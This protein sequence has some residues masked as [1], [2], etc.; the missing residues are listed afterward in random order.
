M[1]IL[2]VT[3]NFT[4][5]GVNP[6][7]LD[8]LAAAL[9]DAGHDVDVIVHSP[10]APRPRG[11]SQG[12]SPRIRILSVGATTQPSSAIAKLRFYLATAVRLHTTGARFAAASVYDLAIYPSIAAFS[13]G[14]PS[15]MRRKGIARRLL[16]VMWDFFPIHQMEI[17]R[18]KPAAIAPALKAIERLAIRR[19]DTIAVMSPANERFLAAYHR[20]LAA[21]I[22]H[23]PPWAATSTAGAPP[24]EANPNDGF[25]AVFGGQ[26]VK[27]RGVDTLLDAAHE[28][29]RRGVPAKI[30][31]AGAG[32]DAASLHAKAKELGL[33]SVEFVGSLPRDEY[34]ALLRRSQAGIAVTVAGVTPPSFPSKIIEYCAS[35][36]PV[37]ACVEQSSDAGSYLERHG[38]GVSVS[39]GDHMALADAI[40]GLV[41]EH[42][43][44]TL[45]A[46]GERARELFLAELSADRAADAIVRTVTPEETA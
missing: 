34:R 37:I 13:F 20:G 30:V 38:V 45:A 16:F 23:I 19:A 10:T 14:F 28:L 33:R 9:A 39:A 3:G 42:V 1:K 41:D 17:G 31:I 36:L 32:T 46:R 44:G 2:L 6:W 21:R 25:T 27:G 29:E 43:S 12:A 4:A 18:I 15:R 40:A 22:V 11:L 26:L 7:L 35:G 8:D 24:V 5:P